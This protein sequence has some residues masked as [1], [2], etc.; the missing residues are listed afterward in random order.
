VFAVRPPILTTTGTA[1]PACAL[2][3]MRALI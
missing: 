2:A 3:P 1:I